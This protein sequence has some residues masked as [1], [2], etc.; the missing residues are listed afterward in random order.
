MQAEDTV[1]AEKANELVVEVDVLLLDVDDLSSLESQ[2]CLHFFLR[3]WLS[4]SSFL[5]L[6]AIELDRCDSES[7]RRGQG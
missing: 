4:T 5:L 2:E 7:T 1:L 6:D 3:D